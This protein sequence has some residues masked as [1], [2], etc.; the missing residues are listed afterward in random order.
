MICREGER[1]LKGKGLRD[2]EESAREKG[3]IAGS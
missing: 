1:V 3:T 2:G